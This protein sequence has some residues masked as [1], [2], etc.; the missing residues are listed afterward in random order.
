MDIY[1]GYFSLDEGQS[2]TGFADALGTFL[3]HLVDEG[4]IESWRLMRRKLGLGPKHLAEFHLMIEVQDL[5][6]LDRAFQDV[7]SR[8]GEIEGMHASVNQKVAAIEFALY[9]DFPDP[10][11]KRGDE[12]F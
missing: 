5:A 2:D 10:Q 8:A 7:S 4:R 12:Q 3:D 1:S 11:R 6:Q 9:R